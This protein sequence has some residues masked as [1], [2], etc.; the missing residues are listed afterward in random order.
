M[1]QLNQAQANKLADTICY[2]LTE[3]ITVNCMPDNWRPTNDTDARAVDDTAHEAVL[4]HVEV[5]L[6]RHLSEGGNMPNAKGFPGLIMAMEEHELTLEYVLRNLNE[7]GV[8]EF[9]TD[10]VVC[11]ADDK[12]FRDFEKSVGTALYVYNHPLQTIIDCYGLDGA[13]LYDYVQQNG[14]YKDEYD[15]LVKQGKVT[16]VDKNEVYPF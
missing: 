7:Q 1:A 10:W 14:Q 5:P 11:W 6:R 4:N 8:C 9:L 13:E 3:Y 12:V 15:E 16:P 2:L